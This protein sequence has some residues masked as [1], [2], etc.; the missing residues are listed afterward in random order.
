M[1]SQIAGR[2]IGVIA[3]QVFGYE[4]SSVNVLSV[5]VAPGATVLMVMPYGESSRTKFLAS[6][7]NP[8]FVMA[9]AAKN[10]CDW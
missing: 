3:D 7:S 8:A 9:Y 10:L 2:P 6:I 1:S 4:G 5:K